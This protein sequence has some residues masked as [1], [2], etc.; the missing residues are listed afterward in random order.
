VVPFYQVPFGVLLSILADD[1]LRKSKGL[2]IRTDFDAKGSIHLMKELE[3]GLSKLFPPARFKENNPITIR[4]EA[5][6]KLCT[7]TEHL[8]QSR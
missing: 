2:V 4:L 6:R 5:L 7:Q 1:L 3:I 8:R